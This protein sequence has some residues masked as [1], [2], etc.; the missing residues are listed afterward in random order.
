MAYTHFFSLRSGRPA[1]DVRAAPWAEIRASATPGEPADY[2]RRVRPEAAPPGLPGLPVPGPAGPTWTAA[3][4]ADVGPG[5]VVGGE[6][7]VSEAARR[8][9][10]GQGAPPGGY[11]SGDGGGGPPHVRPRIQGGP[12]ALEAELARARARVR[13][14][15]SEAWEGGCD[16][17]AA[18]G[19][20]RLVADL[21]GAPGILDEAAI[22]SA[23]TG[24]GAA[25]A[26]RSLA[27]ACEEA[28][29][30]APRR[31]S[32]A[33]YRAAV[34]K[35]EAELA[36]P[37]APLL[38][39]LERGLAPADYYPVVWGPAS[40]PWLRFTEIVWG[41]EYRGP[42]LAD[43]WTTYPLR[44]RRGSLYAGLA[45]AEVAAAAARIPPSYRTLYQATYAPVLWGSPGWDAA[46]DPENLGEVAAQGTAGHAA[47]FS[48]VYGAVV[49]GG[50]PTKHPGEYLGA[51]L[52]ALF[53]Q[54]AGADYSA[55]P[56]I[57]RAA[58][59]DHG[60]ELLDAEH[61]RR[62]F[63]R[64][65]PEPTPEPVLWPVLRKLE[66]AWALLDAINAQHR[67]PHVAGLAASA[68]PA[69]V[70]AA[71]PAPV[72]AALARPMGGPTPAASGRRAARLVVAGV[73]GDRLV[74]VACD[75]LPGLPAEPELLASPG[76]GGLV[77]ALLLAARETGGGT[78]EVMLKYPALAAGLLAEAAALEAP[79]RAAADYTGPWDLYGAVLETAGRGGGRSALDPQDL[80]VSWIQGPGF[81]PG[82][83]AAASLD[84]GHARGEAPGSPGAAA[85]LGLGAAR[86][87]YRALYPALA[88][89]GW[90]AELW[91][92]EYRKAEVRALPGAPPA[93]APALLDSLALALG[94]A[95][96]AALATPLFAPWRALYDSN[97]AL[98][99]AVAADAHGAA[100]GALWGASG[101]PVTWYPGSG[102]VPA[103]ADPVA[104]ACAVLYGARELGLWAGGSFPSASSRAFVRAWYLVRDAALPPALWAAGHKA[105]ARVPWWRAATGLPE[106]DF[107]AS[108][109]AFPTEES[110]RLYLAA[111]AAREPRTP[112]AWEYVAEAR[113]R[114]VE[115]ADP[116]RAS[117]ES[118]S[119]A[120]PHVTVRV[121]ERPMPWNGYRWGE[122]AEVT[123]AVTEPGAADVRRPAR[124][125]LGSDLPPRTPGS[126]VAPRRWDHPGPALPRLLSRTVPAGSLAPGESVTAFWGAAAGPDPGSFVLYGAVGFALTSAARLLRI[127]GPELGL[128]PG[129]LSGG[130]GLGRAPG[131]GTRIRPPY[132]VS[133]IWVDGRLAKRGARAH[134]ELMPADGPQSVL[135]V[136]YLRDGDPPVAY[137]ADLLEAAG[138]GGSPTS[139][140]PPDYGQAHPAAAHGPVPAPAWGDVVLAVSAASEGGVGLPSA[141]SLSRGLGLDLAQSAGPA[142]APAQGLDPAVGFGYAYY[143][144]TSGPYVQRMGGRPRG[145][146]LS[147]Y[148]PVPGALV[149]GRPAGSPPGPRQLWINGARSGPPAHFGTGGSLNIADPPPPPATYA[150][151]PLGAPPGSPWEEAVVVPGL[152]YQALPDVH[153]PP[154]HALVPFSGAL[155][156]VTGAPAGSAFA[157]AWRP[158]R[159]YP[160]D[161]VWHVARGYWDGSG[162][163]CWDGSRLVLDLAPGY[164][165]FY[166]V[167]GRPE[168]VLVGAASH[169]SGA[170]DPLEAEHAFSPVP[171]A[172]ERRGAVFPPRST[173]AYD[174]PGA[175]RARYALARPAGPA[176][177]VAPVRR[178]LRGSGVLFVASLDSATL[179]RWLAKLFGS[180]KVKL[181][182]GVCLGSYPTLQADLRLLAYRAGWWRTWAGMVAGGGPGE[183]EEAFRTDNV[184]AV[185]ALYDTAGAALSGRTVAAHA[186]QYGARDV[187]ELAQ[188]RDPGLTR[189][190]LRA[191]A[192]TAALGF[193]LATAPA[194]PRG[195]LAPTPP[196]P[197]LWDWAAGSPDTTFAVYGEADDFGERE[198][199]STLAFTTS[200]LSYSG[201]EAPKATRG[202]VDA[203]NQTIVYMAD[204]GAPAADIQPPR[205]TAAAG[206]P[207]ERW[208]RILAAQE[209]GGPGVRFIVTLGDADAGL[210]WYAVAWDDA[211][212]LRA[213]AE[214]LYDDWAAALADDEN[215]RV[216]VS[217]EGGAGEPSGGAAMRHRLGLTSF[218]FQGYGAAPG[219]TG[220]AELEILPEA[221]PSSF[222]VRTDRGDILNPGY[223]AR[224]GP[225][226]L[227]SDPALP[228]V[229]GTD[230]APTSTDGAQRGYRALLSYLVPGGRRLPLPWAYDRSGTG[231]PAFGLGR[232]GTWVL[233]GS[234]WP[235][236]GGRRRPRYPIEA[237]ALLAPAPQASDRVATREVTD[238]SAAIGAGALVATL[239]QGAGLV[240][241][242]APLGA[243]FHHSA[244]FPDSP[245][246]LLVRGLPAQPEAFAGH[247]YL[248]SQTEYEQTAVALAPD[249][250]DAP[251]VGLE[252]GTG[253]TDHASF[254]PGQ[255]L[256]VLSRVIPHVFIRGAAFK[257]DAA[258]PANDP[259]IWV[260]Y[261]AGDMRNTMSSGDPGD[262]QSAPYSDFVDPGGAVRLLDPGRWT[263]VRSDAPV[264]G[265]PGM[266]ATEAPG[267]A[268][269]GWLFYPTWVLPAYP[270]PAPAGG[271]RQSGLLYEIF[272]RT[273]GGSGTTGGAVYGGSAVWGV[274]TLNHYGLGG[275]YNYAPTNP[276]AAAA[277]MP[278]TVAL[279][280]WR[281]DVTSPVPSFWVNWRWWLPDYAW[282]SYGGGSWAHVTSL[283]ALGTPSRLARYDEPAGGVPSAAPA[284]L[285]DDAATMPASPP[286]YRYAVGKYVTP[287]GPGETL[288]Y[289]FTKAAAVF[290]QTAGGQPANGAAPGAA[291]VLRAS[292]AGEGDVRKFVT[293]AGA[294]GFE[295]APAGS[296]V[297]VV[298]PAGGAP[299]Y[300]LVDTRTAG[301]GLV[302]A[303]VQGLGRA[304]E[305]RAPVPLSVA[306]MDAPPGVLADAAALVENRCGRW[307]E[308]PAALD[309]AAAHWTTAPVSEAPPQD[310]LTLLPGPGSLPDL[311]RGRPWVIAKYNYYGV[312]DEPAWEVR[313]ELS[314]LEAW[315]AGPGTVGD[316]G[317]G[318]I[319]A[320]GDAVDGSSAKVLQAYRPRPT[321]NTGARPPRPEERRA[322]Y[323]PAGRLSG[324]GFRHADARAAE[325]GPVYR[326]PESAGRAWNWF[327]EGAPAY[328]RDAAGNL[329]APLGGVPG[330]GAAAWH[331]ERHA[332]VEA[333]HP[334]DLGGGSTVLE[335]CCPTRLVA[336]EGGRYTFDPPLPCATLCLLPADSGVPGAPRRLLERERRAAGV[337][338]TKLIG[339]YI[340]D[341]HTYGSPASTPGRALVDGRRA[342]L[343]G[344]HFP[345]PGGREPSLGLRQGLGG[346]LKLTTGAGSGDYWGADA[347]YEDLVA[348]LPDV[349]LCANAGG[350]CARGQVVDISGGTAVKV[351]AGAEPAPLMP[352]GPES[353]VSPQYYL[354]GAGGYTATIEVRRASP[355]GL[356]SPGPPGSTGAHLEVTAAG[357]AT[358][359]LGA[360]GVVPVAMSTDQSWPGGAG[361]AYGADITW[362]PARGAYQWADGRIC[363]PPPA[364]EAP[365]LPAGAP[366][367]GLYTAA[368]GDLVAVTGSGETV[369]LRAHAPDYAYPA[370]PGRLYRGTG[371]YP[372][373]AYAERRRTAVPGAV[374]PPT[375]LLAE[376][377]GS[378]GQVRARG[379]YRD[380][381]VAA[382][383]L[384][385]TPFPIQGTGGGGDPELH[386]TERG[387]GHPYY[388][389]R[390]L[391]CRS[392]A[393]LR[394][395][396]A[397]KVLGSDADPAL[398]SWPD[399]VEEAALTC[400]H[401][402]FAA[403]VRGNERNFRLVFVGGAGD[404]GTA[405]TA[406]PAVRPDGE[407][408]TAGLGGVLDAL[409][410]APGA[411]PLPAWRWAFLFVRAVHGLAVRVREG[412]ASAPGDAAGLLGICAEYWAAGGVPET[413][414]LALSVAANVAWPGDQAG[415][416]LNVPAPGPAQ[417]GTGDALATSLL[418]AAE[419]LWISMALDEGDPGALPP[420]YQ[421]L[422]GGPASTWRGPR[423]GTYGPAGTGFGGTGG[424]GL[425]EETDAG[426]AASLAAEVGGGMLRLLTRAG[427][428]FLAAGGGPGPAWRK[429]AV[430]PWDFTWGGAGTGSRAFWSPAPGS[431]AGAAGSLRWG[432]PWGPSRALGG[433]AEAW[434]HGPSFAPGHAAASYAP[435]LEGGALVLAGAGAGQRLPADLSL[436]PA[437]SVGAVKAAG[438]PP[439]HTDF[440]LPRLCLQD[441]ALEL[442]ADFPG[443]AGTG[444]SRTAGHAPLAALDLGAG[445]VVDGAARTYNLSTMIPPEDL[446]V[447]SPEGL[448]AS[449]SLTLRARL[450]S[451]GLALYTEEAGY[452]ALWSPIDHAPLAPWV[453]GLGSVRGTLVSDRDVLLALGAYHAYLVRVGAADLLHWAPEPAALVS[454]RALP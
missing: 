4:Y 396:G 218:W 344:R 126:S 313:G 146:A 78:V 295:T 298:I 95:G 339:L 257:N 281:P 419:K 48:S 301:P 108:L 390:E 278:G 23:L 244:V 450:F 237:P 80:L 167:T 321:W 355:F 50:A 446:Y 436:H 309:W 174:P 176:D 306:A 427:P 300:V 426:E 12:E 232:A 354:D 185:R 86:Q 113:E 255:A 118:I 323:P 90:G 120:G 100:F 234:G 442:R 251:G 127:E 264:F 341:Q 68:L 270:P 345:W 14:L 83:A 324:G 225:L 287:P 292:L 252:E 326:P 3:D 411:N 128:G 44:V 179:G 422:A 254:A 403:L 361:Y 280:A 124:G 32:G 189:E 94:T 161:E 11:L 253:E 153:V 228:S 267:S 56:F 428:L 178:L 24:A 230:G 182:R 192:E 5:A 413:A 30:K 138:G 163:K 268:A 200:L 154:A 186:L 356:W 434:L 220:R 367:P 53:D 207:L 85:E 348:G 384:S 125:D 249:G 385:P 191:L 171:G 417:L 347:T 136:G 369:D 38:R 105:L 276:T 69:H 364:P 349:F 145:G 208:G 273:A 87:I 115:A 43:L 47:Y 122:A 35:I 214:M 64:S 66:E 235:V 330:E 89:G 438:A 365:P 184:A 71:L 327:E 443:A 219:P 282:C 206:A 425:V 168:S 196:G 277:S 394:Y 29:T 55:A 119:Y 109:E 370:Y 400:N 137:A 272:R 290:A 432:C 377:G 13:A 117:L 246:A 452:V 366:A 197:W 405:R 162:V 6:L 362:D 420:P 2:G 271:P 177:D 307:L 368:A 285:V 373:L 211:P 256:G 159:P 331:G 164:A 229:I 25:A 269:V 62:A 16:P 351:G 10:G 205:P 132:P 433:D 430:Q 393:R 381:L 414:A 27:S 412:A 116:A 337:H 343:A 265:F 199:L 245:A 61:V 314:D 312:P 262:W 183:I 451:R 112:V 175:P 131:G 9:L 151:E 102:S 170:A 318:E 261:G 20:A 363:D 82:Y 401:A 40:P 360:G 346:D 423:P 241:G 49:K 7:V 449:T 98:A 329:L 133:E 379:V 294:G 139:Q 129:R 387:G 395:P 325:A 28:L 376:E 221:L 142:T 391:R 316:R 187:L 37:W 15:R 99:A 357:T 8:Y 92:V 291:G 305:S 36:K 406:C 247:Y 52:A 371:P 93:H 409:P 201:A 416:L 165:A 266:H 149:L 239:D 213:T 1:I 415:S 39:V 33:N 435:L 121:A 240:V 288:D 242:P 441:G 181:G 70:T 75:N 284:A 453:P 286:S 447:Y 51:L 188:A 407:I 263:A 19:V 103:A 236:D 335:V 76:P 77:E 248:S 448:A 156:H 130:M 172:W 157:L 72:L 408:Q 190:V 402:L 328:L 123:Y 147:P 150:L 315:P 250:Y 57:M 204:P 180:T 317:E 372:Y 383:C 258:D 340:A 91:K 389:L 454:R 375:P 296:E 195:A 212:R 110:A 67:D 203:P 231:A 166:P 198:V 141:P 227:P 359:H 160:G 437:G 302:S 424:A 445:L 216:H 42:A 111:E 429:P 352:G 374:L 289:Y 222:L 140:P 158:D 444:I 299:H 45:A 342:E 135:V 322:G 97:A 308:T 34:S 410:G 74:R 283:S 63:F 107:R 134:A 378:R 217:G 404:P 311:A 418:G 297:N 223:M 88:P 58:R 310:V 54:E 21:T 421:G 152:T 431:G 392:P 17:A 260:A 336:F 303:A 73:L 59:L 279:G 144:T 334:R 46:L 215:L 243:F 233:E 210:S 226:L 386:W 193:P 333:G 382:M 155:G 293:G 26:A 275:V 224:T 18:I 439:S 101:G 259:P 79:K 399:R 41:S 60:S 209:Q 202:L 169:V 358:L 332:S 65:T 22:L 338:E 398:P 380:P 96:L 173:L 84:Q 350:G 104:T 106:S 319:R 440:G 274:R 143:E 397:L 114:F 353:G 238:A 194:A 148:S 304:P 320:W 388:S 31:L 81:A